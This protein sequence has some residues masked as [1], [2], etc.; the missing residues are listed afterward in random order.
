M[1]RKNPTK[2]FGTSTRPPAQTQS[3]NIIF[4]HVPSCDAMIRS[5]DPI[6]GKICQN[7]PIPPK[8]LTDLATYPYSATNENVMKLMSETSNLSQVL[9]ETVVSIKI[10]AR[11]RVSEQEETR[12]CSGF[13]VTPLYIFT[14]LHPFELDY[15]FEKERI[16]I[17]GHDYSGTG[18]M[19]N[20]NE[21]LG[22]EAQP[23]AMRT[24]FGG[25]FWEIRSDNADFAIIKVH[26]PLNRTGA[27][28]L[29][30]PEEPRWL[31]KGVLLSAGHPGVYREFDIPGCYYK[32]FLRRL[33]D[34]D[35]QKKQVVLREHFLSIVYHYKYPIVSFGTASGSSNV[36]W[37]CY[38]YTRMSTI[39]GLAGSPI[40]MAEHQDELVGMAVGGWA[41]QSGSIFLDAQTPLVKL[42]MEYCVKNS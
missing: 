21:A 18:E 10:T 2:C 13:F 29:T 23:A 14:V 30:I 17:E 9:V 6:T 20:L 16:K 25:Q 41:G 37:G 32:G 27:K 1:A 26:Q 38:Q 12:Y 7:P 39:E 15:S 5:F 24:A 11:N 40:V 19:V 28:F 31:K 3:Q 8:E 35:P 42:A 22:D 4:P 34:W 36:R 33:E